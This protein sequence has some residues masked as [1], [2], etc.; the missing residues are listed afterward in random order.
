VH[1][2]DQRVG[3]LRGTKQSFLKANGSCKKYAVKF[4]VY[5]PG[6]VEAT[7][8]DFEMLAQAFI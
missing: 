3:L 8:M 5:L 1:P 4:L 2:I 6:S 7:P